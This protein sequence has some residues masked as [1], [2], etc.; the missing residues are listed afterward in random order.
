MR[1]FSLAGISSITLYDQLD[2]FANSDPVLSGL[3][4]GTFVPLFDHVLIKSSP[5]FAYSRADA[6]GLAIVDVNRD[7][8]VRVE[9]LFVEDVTD[10]QWNQIVERA[11]FRVVAG[12]SRI[13]IVE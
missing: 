3:G 13:E 8:E 10:P 1:S 5:H 4:I 2:H 11:R 6:Y 12:S 9:Y 7:E